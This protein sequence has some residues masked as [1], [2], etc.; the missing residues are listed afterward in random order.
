V[1]AARFTAKCPGCGE[2]IHEDDQIGRV[3]GDWVCEACVDEAG[4]EDE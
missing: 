4:G 1:I 2:R 3:D